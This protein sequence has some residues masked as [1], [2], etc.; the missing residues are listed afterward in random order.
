MKVLKPI[1]FQNSQLI[2]TTATDLY[3]TWSSGTTYA[4]GGKVTYNGKY[5]E[6]LQASN[7][8]KQ[9]DTNPTW[10]LDLGASNK[11][12]MFDNVV[13]TSTNATTSLTVVYS[14]GAVFNSIALIDVDAAVIKVTVR[15]GLNGT[16]VYENAAGLS[17]LESYSW[18]DYFFNDP[19]LKRTQVVLSGI[20][21]YANGHIT[22]ELTNSTG[23]AVSIAQAIAGDLATLG[24]T[25]YGAT[26]GIVDYSV[27]Q[28]DEFGN[29]TFVKRAFSKRLNATVNLDN[30]QL[31]RVQNYLYSL[32]ATPAVWVA[33]DDPTYEEALVVY[34]F[35]KDFSTEIS[36][37]TF[38]QC[39]LEIESLT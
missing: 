27:K 3:A 19:L 13:S 22:I 26:A 21:P 14:P 16:I 28:T 37:P 4:L 25:Q 39:S 32:R 23:S 35:Y 11:Y 17:G 18:Y 9:P 38:S 36:Y 34:G 12:A 7:L 10:W 24:M 29:T 20:P 2:S 6:S 31:N 15:D 1:L 5:Y 33:T 30:S 8:N